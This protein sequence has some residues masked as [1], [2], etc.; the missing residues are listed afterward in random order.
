M[1]AIAIIMFLKANEIPKFQFF[2]DS[3]GARSTSAT[4]CT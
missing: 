2:V 3:A 1:K 4:K